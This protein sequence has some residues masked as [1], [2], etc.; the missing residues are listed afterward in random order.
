MTIPKRILLFCLILTLFSCK[1]SEFES[2]LISSGKKWIYI[3]DEKINPNSKMMFYVKFEENGE[4]DNYF[5]SNNQKNVY[6]DGNHEQGKWKY[7]EK[8][9]VLKIHN[10]FNFKV[11]K[12]TNDTIYLLDLK[13]NNKTLFVNLESKKR[14]K[15]SH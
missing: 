15:A 1:K 7:S 5:L 14:I 11:L 4:C 13:Y 10:Y 2:L 8:D 3:N 9:S 6:V 12:F